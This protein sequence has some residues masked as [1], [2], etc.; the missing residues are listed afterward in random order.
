MLPPPSSTFD[1]TLPP[2]E[3]LLP[4]PLPLVRH[5]VLSWEIA[6]WGLPI[7]VPSVRGLGGSQTQGMHNGISGSLGGYAGRNTP[8]DIEGLSMALDEW[9]TW[10]TMLVVVEMSIAS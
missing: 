9:A 6:L 1:L 8:A 3:V 5:N 4:H 7:P 2:L 10:E